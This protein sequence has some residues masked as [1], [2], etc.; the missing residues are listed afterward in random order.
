MRCS[1]HGTA[2]KLIMKTY[3]NAAMCDSRRLSVVAESMLFAL[4]NDDTSLFVC[5]NKHHLAVTSKTVLDGLWLAGTFTDVMLWAPGQDG[6]G[7]GNK[8]LFIL[9]IVSSVTNA[10]HT[11]GAMQLYSN[12]TL[13][14]KHFKATTEEQR[15]GQQNKH[16]IHSSP[17]V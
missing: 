1:C 12:P 5:G 11:H 6:M 13:F 15:A 16:K 8:C 17:K 14:V 9:P 7:Y 3:L 10:K 2:A 4:K